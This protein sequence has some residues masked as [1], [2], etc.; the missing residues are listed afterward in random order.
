MWSF[1]RTAAAVL[2]LFTIIYERDSIINICV[3]VKIAKIHTMAMTRG[4][5]FLCTMI[6]CRIFYLHANET[7]SVEIESATDKIERT[8]TLR[9]KIRSKSEQLSLYVDIK[10]IIHRVVCD[11]NHQ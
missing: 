5:L 3:C 9:K 4:L 7:R 11:Y 8:R 10:Y 1:Q 6:Q 2:T